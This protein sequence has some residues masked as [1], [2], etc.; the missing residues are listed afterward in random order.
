MGLMGRTLAKGLG[1]GAAGTT[2][3]NAVT[4]ADMALR[5]RGPSEL[6]Q[7]S[8]EHLAG[9][10]GVNIPG[11]G[12][13]RDHRVE[14]FGALGGLGTGLLI[15]VAAAAF[16]PITRRLPVPLASLLI[17]GSAMAM[18][19]VPMSKLGLTDPQKW[20][21]SD[22]LADALPHLAYGVVTAAMLR[23]IGG[24]GAGVRK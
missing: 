18:T 16:G 3:L 12:E 2:A 1:A 4:Y 17:G 10:F 22:W 21:A 23:R 13:T 8:I 20:S 5:G 15:G 14:A 24:R 7:Q 6:P 19:D 9:Q 11:A